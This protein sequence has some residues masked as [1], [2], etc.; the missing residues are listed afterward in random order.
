VFAGHVDDTS[1]V[2]DSQS[3]SGFRAR[4]EVA[5]LIVAKPDRADFFGG[6]QSLRRV[7]M[8][9]SQ[10]YQVSAFVWMSASFTATLMRPPLRLF[11]LES[12]KRL[13]GTNAFETQ[14]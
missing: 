14:A 8:K 9:K 6:Q 4:R 11:S 1:N 5:I 7:A 12:S 10:R 2:T 3:V 13:S